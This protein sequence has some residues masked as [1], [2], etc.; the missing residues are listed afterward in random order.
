MQFGGSQLRR[1]SA[2]RGLEWDRMTEAERE[3]F[4][5]DLL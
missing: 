3:A 1:K 5:E 4:V 2:E